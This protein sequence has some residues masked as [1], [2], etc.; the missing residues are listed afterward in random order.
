MKYLI[1]NWKMNSVNLDLWE[2]KF[3]DFINSH[4]D[5]PQPS[6]VKLIVCLNLYD[7][8]V[9]SKKINT[10][11]NPI[12]KISVYMLKMFRNMKK[13]LLRDRFLQNF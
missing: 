5:F 1:A 12:F 10:S 4:K 2:Q 7:Y 9:F 8:F 13:E 3:V 11:K 6:E